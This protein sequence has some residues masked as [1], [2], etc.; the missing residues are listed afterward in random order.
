M[1]SDFKISDFSGYC[2]TKII[3]CINVEEN[4]QIIQ[5]K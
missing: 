5:K 4:L 3:I 1:L 2:V